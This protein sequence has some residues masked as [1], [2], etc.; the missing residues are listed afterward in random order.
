MN[1]PILRTISWKEIGK[2]FQSLLVPDV[3]N[4]MIPLDSGLEANVFKISTP[5]TTFVLKVWNRDSKPDVSIQY[6]LLKAL[7]NRGMAVSRPFGWGIDEN[8]N[9]VL[10][11]SF[12]GTPINKVDKLKLTEIANMLTEIHNFQIE[13]LGGKTMPRYDFIHYFFP[14]IDGQLDIKELLI[15]LVG[16]S[17]MEQNCLIHGDYNLGNILE[18]DGKYTII[19]WTNVQLGDPRYDIAWSIILIWIYVSERHCSTYRSVFLTK[20]NYAREEL[21]KFEA[22]ACLRWILL[23]RIAV[24]PKRS[25]TI[26]TVR[27]ILM[28][29]KYLNEKL[30]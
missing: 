6:T 30:L 12:D 4:N 1:D 13:I 29:N 23:N 9:Q 10:L 27:T 16:S 21:E 17:N 15:Q 24:L 14:E 2:G 28:K 5:A 8:N 19:D 25:N 11:T 26:S 18:S 20:N 22:I 3:P 7:Y